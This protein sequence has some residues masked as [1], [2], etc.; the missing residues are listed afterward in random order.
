MLI[1][2]K[3]SSPSNT[4]GNLLFMVPLKSAGEEM[5]QELLEEKHTDLNFL[6]L[7]SEV[8]YFLILPRLLFIM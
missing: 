7:V 3:S 2:S 4:D 1:Q 5:K 6:Q 8:D